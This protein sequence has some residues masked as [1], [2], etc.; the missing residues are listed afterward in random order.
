MKKLIALELLF[1]INT[2]RQALYE[3]LI[4]VVGETFIRAIMYAK[5]GFQ[6]E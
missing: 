2:S 6:A 1:I 5:N 3:L 4:M